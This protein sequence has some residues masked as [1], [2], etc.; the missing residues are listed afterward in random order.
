MSSK[1]KQTYFNDIEQKKISEPR[2]QQLKVQNQQFKIILFFLKKED[3]TFFPEIKL[4]SERNETK[5]EVQRIRYYKLIIFKFN[6]NL[7]FSALIIRID[8][9]VNSRDVRCT[10]Y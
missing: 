6:N 1:L 4:Q 10:A 5:K 3:A 2:N 9:H 7:K 8:Q